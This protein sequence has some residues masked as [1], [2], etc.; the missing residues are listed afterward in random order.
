MSLS[1]VQPHQTHGEIQSA[2]AYTLVAVQLLLVLSLYVV[3]QVVLACANL[4]T[5]RTNTFFWHV[6]TPTHSHVCVY[7]ILREK[8]LFG[9]I[10]AS[11]RFNMFEHVCSQR[12]D[13][14]EPF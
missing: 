10:W 5:L 7:F 12:F 1:Y 9:T 11:E 2:T 4:S 13:T 6:H 8:L 3:F 14:C